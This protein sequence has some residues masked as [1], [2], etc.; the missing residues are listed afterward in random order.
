M[1]QCL[2]VI[3]REVIKLYQAEF[4]LMESI[5]IIK[6]ARFIKLPVKIFDAIIETIGIT[7]C[8]EQFQIMPKSI[9]EPIFTLLIELQVRYHGMEPAEVFFEL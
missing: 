9:D 5:G 8:I 7:T 6:A 3:P 2:V 1:V 4:R